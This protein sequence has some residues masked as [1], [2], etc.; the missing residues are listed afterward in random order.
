MFTAYVYNILYIYIQADPNLMPYIPLWA[1]TTIN[2]SLQPHAAA[3]LLFQYF[4]CG[5]KERRGWKSKCKAFLK[6]IHIFS[7][8]PMQQRK[9]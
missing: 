3:S 4:T 2:A 7:S 5:A 6:E 1:K 9:R 8:A